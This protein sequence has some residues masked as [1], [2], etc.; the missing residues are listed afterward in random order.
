MQNRRYW[1]LRSHSLS[2]CSN[3]PTIC[4]LCAPGSPA[5]WKYSLKAHFRECHRL[6]NPSHFPCPVGQSQSEKYGM[7]IVWQGCFKKRKSYNSKSKRLA[8][9]LAVSEAHRPGLPIIARATHHHTIDTQ[10]SDGESDNNSTCDHNS[11]HD[12]SEDN[13]N[14]NDI[15]DN[16]SRLETLHH[17]LHVPSAPSESTLPSQA[18]SRTPVPIAVPPTPGPSTPTLTWTPISITTTSPTAMLPVTRDWGS[19]N[20][21]PV[22]SATPH[23]NAAPDVNINTKGLQSLENKLDNALDVRP[24]QTRKANALTLNACECGITISD[25]EIQEGKTVMKCTVEG[26]EMVW[27]SDSLLHYHFFH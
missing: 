26:C 18:P 17:D 24:R 23:V 27:V 21:T 25:D 15:A 12:N 19:P 8:P 5:V 14:D 20:S 2:P 1:S 9:H 10:D 16:N 7:K 3:V 13:E 4:P 6:I 22:I 11:E